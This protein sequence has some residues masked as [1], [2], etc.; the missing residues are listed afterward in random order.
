M[1]SQKNA[2]FRNNDPSGS[3]RNQMLETMDFNDSMEDQKFQMKIRLRQ[4]ESLTKCCAIGLSEK[5]CKKTGMNDTMTKIIQEGVNAFWK[6]WFKGVSI[7]VNACSDA[8]RS[9]GIPSQSLLGRPGF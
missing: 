9:L 6:H 3:R 5:L 4:Y 8:S 2:D 7:T 1:A